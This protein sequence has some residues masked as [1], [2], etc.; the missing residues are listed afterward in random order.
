MVFFLFVCFCFLIF[1]YLFI[2]LTASVLAVVCG[3]YF[4]DQGLNPGPLHWEHG[5]LAIGPPRKSLPCFLLIPLPGERDGGA[6]GHAGCEE[7]LRSFYS[8]GL[9]LVSWLHLK[10]GWSSLGSRLRAACVFVSKMMSPLPRRNA[11]MVIWWQFSLSPPA[12]KMR[13]SQVPR[14]TRR[15]WQA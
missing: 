7:L 6:A 9:L 8:G 1:I 4:P 12:F 2:H 11:C 10:K 15:W 13:V 14:L 3:T 5:I